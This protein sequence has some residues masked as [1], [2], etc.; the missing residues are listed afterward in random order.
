MDLHEGETI[1]WRGHPS[2]RAHMTFY[3]KWGIPALLPAIV[4]GAWDRAGNDTW[5][6]YWQWLLITVLLLALVLGVD[7]VQRAAT[8]YLITT[9]RIRIREGILSRSIHAASVDRVQS[10]NTLQ[11]L[12][13]RI[14]GVGT[15]DFDTAGTAENDDDFRFAGVADPQG[16]VRQVSAYLR[17]RPGPVSA[18]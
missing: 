17:E 9:E 4:M 10:V 1:V 14:L 8:L 16:I 5:L 18:R 11:S 12:L 2:W 7:A 13:D 3:L 15:V 6:P